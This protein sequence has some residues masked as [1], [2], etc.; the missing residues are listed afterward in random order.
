MRV[1]F[2]IKL[3]F[4]TFLILQRIQLYIINVY[5]YSCK[6]PLLLLYLKNLYF[7]DRFS[8]N[9]QILKFHEIIPVGA[10]LFHADRRT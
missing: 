2:S 5:W 7:I 8:K 4:E 9:N 10:E 3:L 6:V 1:L